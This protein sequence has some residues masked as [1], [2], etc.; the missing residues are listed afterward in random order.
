MYSSLI[1]KIG[2]IAAAL[3]TLPLYAA[4]DAP[5]A[6]GK[7]SAGDWDFLM[8]RVR[9]HEE[10]AFNDLMDVI[11]TKRCPGTPEE[12]TSMLKIAAGH[13]NKKAQYLL[14]ECYRRG[15]GVRPNEKMAEVWER[16][17]Y[18]TRD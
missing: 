12:L 8:R 10:Q 13:G 3:C 16:I 17:Y 15:I 1:S 2:I 18:N 11:N 6:D 5:A 7:I 4:E 14:A 9:N